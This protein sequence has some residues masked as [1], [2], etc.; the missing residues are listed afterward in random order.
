MLSHNYRRGST[1]MKKVFSYKRIYILCLIPISFFLILMAKENS[2]FAEQIYAKHIY[3]L[4]SQLISTISGMVPFS[5]A[6]IVVVLFPVMIL[7]MIVRFLYIIRKDKKNRIEKLATE[8]LNVICI[9]SVLLFCFTL[10]AGLNY[11]RYSFSTYSNLEIKAST[12]EELY[13]LTESLATEANELRAQVPEVDKD[14]VFQLSES[15]YEVAKDA[16]EAYKLLAKEYPVLTGSH[17]APKPVFFS[18]LMS[19][20]E[21]TGVFF[22]F[23]ME[24]NVNTDVPDYSIP[25][26]MLHE[27][28]HLRGFMRED[29]AN[30]LAYLAGMESDNVELK[31]SS[32]MLAL[33]IAGNALYEQNPD[34]YFRIRDMYSEEVQKDIRANSAYWLQYDDTAVSAMSNKINDT[35]LKANNQADGVKSYGRMLDL[36]L[37]NYRNDHEIE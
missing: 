34:L 33:V 19:S 18:K 29:E 27:L 30:Y 4:I 9:G 28:A 32:T 15:T 2:Y 20:T 37:A 21:I 22:P 6:E 13:A 12:V 14:G 10:F 36:L 26:T 5:I 8:I 24:A 23:T 3:R 17:A 25:S 7:I 31:Y 1:M 35:Y 16:S 11:Y